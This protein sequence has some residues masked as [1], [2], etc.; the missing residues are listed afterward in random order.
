M[1]RQFVL[2]VVDRVWESGDIY[3]DQYEGYY[4]ID[5][6]EYKDQDQM[7]RE[8]NCLIHRKPCQFRK[9]VGRDRLNQSNSEICV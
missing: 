2:E 4:C 5:C 9:E 3:L 8:H 1:H 6:E 7:D